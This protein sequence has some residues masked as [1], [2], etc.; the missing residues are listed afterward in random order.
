MSKPSETSCPAGWVIR[1][2]E[3]DKAPLYVS[4]TPTGMRA[5]AATT[6]HGDI[7]VWGAAYDAALALSHGY[8]IRL[9]L[10]EHPELTATVVPLAEAAPPMAPVAASSKA[11]P[12]RG[13]YIAS[14]AHH[15]P[16]WQALRASGCPIVSTWIDESGIG[17][18]SD[19]GALWARSILEASG[20][21][22][23]VVFNE[24]GER[25]KGALVEIGAAL[26]TGTPVF[27]AGLDCDPEGKEY[28]VVRH[29]FVTRCLSLQHAINLAT[30]I[31][32][33]AATYTAFVEGTGE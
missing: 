29:P 26:A 1:L 5:A 3:A 23:V 18:T 15:G 28:T 24:S 33:R 19:W 9:L 7:R 20:A 14:K 16:R 22:A 13:I 4:R 6:A 30:A 21:A 12:G 10:R 8:H 2:D 17:D 32:A 25:M 27:W 11:A 31:A